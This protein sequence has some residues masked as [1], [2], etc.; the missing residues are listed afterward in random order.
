MRN[1]RVIDS[2]RRRALRAVLTCGFVCCGWGCHQHYYYY[3]NQPA[4]PPGTVMPSTVTAGPL[5]DVFGDGIINSNADANSNSIR[6]TTVSEG[7]KSRVVVSE[8]AESKPRFGWRISDPD[9]PPAL[10]E[11]EG[12][13]G[14]SSVKK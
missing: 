14:D 9:A 12:A 10:T 2:P 13:Y 1:N 3:G 8:P 5:C 7:R 4:C 6:S 11:V